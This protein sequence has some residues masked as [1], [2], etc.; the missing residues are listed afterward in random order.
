MDRAG[1]ARAGA[2]A[3]ADGR[4][5]SAGIEFTMAGLGIRMAGAARAGLAGG[6]FGLTV[7]GEVRG[8]PAALTL[9]D[10][11]LVEVSP[12]PRG[13]YGYL[14]FDAEIGVT[15]L[16]GSRATNL[17]AGLG[18]F[19]GRALKHGDRLT[20]EP[21]GAAP[22]IVGDRKTPADG[23]IRVLPGLHAE[24]LGKEVW[25]AFAGAEFTMSS[26]LD[27]MGVRLADPSGVFAAHDARTLV[28][29]AVVPGDIQILG[30]GTPVI[31]MRDHQPTGGY[32]R[33]ATVIGA[34][35]DRL[36]QTRPRAALSFEPVTLEHAHRLAR[37]ARR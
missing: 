21:A 24:M 27:R 4:A 9:A 10:G 17:M 33:I 11:D 25:T 30:D 2:L 36:A 13:V 18:G 8:W 14:R 23:P 7:N 35:L 26:R 12:G 29:D 28:S 6:G 15:E 20:L 3:G 19:A 37:E 22:P 1:F 34:D 16:L 32:P 31:L 5:G